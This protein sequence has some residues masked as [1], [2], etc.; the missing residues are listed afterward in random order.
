MMQFAGYGMA[1]MLPRACAHTYTH[2]Q[3]PP[4]AHTHRRA[5]TYLQQQVN[6]YTDFTNML[7]AVQRSSSQ[8]FVDGVMQA[9]SACT[10]D[11]VLDSWDT[12]QVGAHVAPLISIRYHIHRRLRTMAPTTCSAKMSRATTCATHRKVHQPHTHTHT[13]KVNNY[14]QEV[15]SSLKTG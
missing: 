2:T 9:R 6:F 13:N 4:R 10:D 7:T 12:T 15:A 1:G 14:T 3:P 5:A 8:P 11:A